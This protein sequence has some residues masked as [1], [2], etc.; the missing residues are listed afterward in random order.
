MA[1]KHSYFSNSLRIYKIPSFFILSHFFYFFLQ[2]IL[3]STNFTFENKH[4]FVLSVKAKSKPYSF[5]SCHISS[6]FWSPFNQN[7]FE[8]I[9]E[10]M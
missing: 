7:Y 5:N 1:T 10:K 4:I 8:G 3:A 6:S 2:V 9:L